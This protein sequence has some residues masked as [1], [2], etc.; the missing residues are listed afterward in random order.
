MLRAGTHPDL[1][2]ITKELARYSDEAEVR[3]KKLITIPK[4]VVEEHLIIPATRAPQIRN[5]GRAG[6]V[7]IVDEAE[8]LD[9]SPTNAPVQN[10][11]LKTLEEPDGRTVIILVTSHADRLLT[12]IRSRSQQVRFGPLPAAEMRKWVASRAM[13]IDREEAV[14]LMEYAEG[15]PGEYLVGKE[16]GLYAWWKELSPMLAGAAKG[17]YALGLGPR[18]AELIEAEAKGVVEA[19]PQ[20]SK[21][22]ATRAA[23]GRMF[24][25]VSRFYR[26]H[27]RQGLPRA[28]DGGY[29]D[30]ACRAID[31]V[32]RAEQLVEAQVK[33]TFIGEW[34]SAE[35]TASAG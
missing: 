20:S 10:S 30:A 22:A 17:K 23:A 26:D 6:K 14:W 15:S 13:E 1:H 16:M 19:S 9:R 4:E 27:L 18:M 24:R 12:T 3:D 34:L 31:A 25:M 2:V 21:E 7:F 29:D 5:E 32:R 33:L 28:V 35:L 11:I 8:L